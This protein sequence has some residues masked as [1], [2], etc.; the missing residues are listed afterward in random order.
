MPE[1]KLA[2]IDSNVFISSYKGNEK[3]SDY[4]TALIEKIREGELILA[5]PA[6]LLSEV[7]DAIGRYMGENSAKMVENVLRDMVT[8]W[9]DCNKNFCIKAG[10]TGHTYKIYGCDAIYVQVASD[11]EI[12]FVSLD[13][14]DLVDKLKKENFQAFKVK[15]F[16][17]K[18]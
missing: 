11:F 17:D 1:A 16:L 12:P 18:F 9:V 15:E 2:V 5:E 4:C 13:E 10:H 7:I 8:F 14:K 6:I 3:S